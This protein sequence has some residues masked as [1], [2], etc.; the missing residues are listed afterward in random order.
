MDA[1]KSVVAALEAEKVHLKLA[2]EEGVFLRED[3]KNRFE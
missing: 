3:Y 2:L 1:E